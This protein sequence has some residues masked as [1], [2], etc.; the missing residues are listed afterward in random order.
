MNQGGAI[1]DLRPYIAKLERPIGI[2]TKMY[3]M[4]PIRIWFSQC[5]E[6]DILLTMWVKG[7]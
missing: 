7:P 3:M 4:H 2:G 5:T 6:Q 1:I